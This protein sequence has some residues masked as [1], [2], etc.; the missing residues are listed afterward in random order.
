M[1]GEI[2]MKIK[3][4]RYF[5]IVLF[6]AT[7]MLLNLKFTPPVFANDSVLEDKRY[8]IEMISV[9]TIHNERS[10][11]EFRAIDKTHNS[12]NKITIKK[13]YDIERSFIFE[14]YL[15]L[16]CRSIPWGTNGGPWVDFIQCDLSTGKMIRF[17][18]LEKYY[19][20]FDEKYLISTFYN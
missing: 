11:I 19:L 4:N 5:S 9:P 3:K 14:N 12:Q 1:T 17:K 8:R 13:A 10:K 7:I 16:I 20:S 6:W 2:K 15:N 18:M